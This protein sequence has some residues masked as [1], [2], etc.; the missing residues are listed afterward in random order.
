VLFIYFLIQEVQVHLIIHQV[1][2]QA[3]VRVVLHLQVAGIM[4][5]M[6]DIVHMTMMMISTQMIMNLAQTIKENEY[7]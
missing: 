7:V 4:T 5:I 6:T 2:H 3:I 1:I